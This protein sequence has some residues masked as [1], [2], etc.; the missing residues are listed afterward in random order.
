MLRGMPDTGLTRRRLLA[1]LGGVGVV[2]LIPGCADDEGDKAATTTAPTTT[3]A[4][5]TTETAV[6]CTLSPELTE[7]PFYLDLDLVRRDITEGRPGT[8]LDLSVKVVDGQSCEAIRDAAVDIWHCDAAGVYS[9]D[10]SD[11]GTFL[12]GIQ[13]TDGGGEAGFQ[14]IF[15]GWYSGRAVHIH[16][17]VHLGG[18]ETYTGQLFF[19]EAVTEAVYEAEPYNARS[20]PDTPNEADGIFGQGG[21]QTVVSLSPAGDGYRGA[22]TL[23]V[24]R[25]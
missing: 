3:A 15:P 25:T 18:T 16:V 10:Q 23:G 8:A 5:T 11:S 7:G 20:G 24:L 2:A 14:T 17:K 21:D 22:V 1:W 13:V 12:R 9:G 19:D 4:T 6:D